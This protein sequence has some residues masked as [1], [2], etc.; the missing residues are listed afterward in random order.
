MDSKVALIGRWF[1]V[2][3][4]FQSCFQ[5]F[6]TVQLGKYTL[7]A[8]EPLERNLS[9]RLR[10]YYLRCDASRDL[11]KENE[12]GCFCLKLLTGNT[13]FIFSKPRLFAM[14][15]IS[16]AK[17][18]YWRLRSLS[19]A[20]ILKTSKKTQQ[21]HAIA[22]PPIKNIK[23]SI[24][25]WQYLLNQDLLK[26]ESWA[27]QFHGNI[28]SMP[29]V[30]WRMLRSPDRRCSTSFSLSYS[31]VQH[32]PLTGAFCRPVYGVCMCVSNIGERVYDTRFMDSTI[33]RTQIIYLYV[34]LHA[35][36]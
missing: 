22:Q 36:I 30:C 26:G 23:Q 9:K 7:M 25:K 33:L 15:W 31:L 34:H 19:I 16:I 35:G 29:P 11:C 21:V 13:H 17:A 6:I 2:G 24:W 12:N 3:G 18:P 28:T 14:P 10:T 20:K 32:V 5:S 8:R 4:K 27:C 1:I